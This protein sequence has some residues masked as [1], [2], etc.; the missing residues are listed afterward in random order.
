MEKVIQDV[1]L[2]EARQYMQQSNFGCWRTSGN[3]MK[4]ETAVDGENVE[5]W[6]FLGTTFSIAGLCVQKNNTMVMG[7]FPEFIDFWECMKTDY[8]QLFQDNVKGELRLF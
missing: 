2:E 6:I 4:E 8:S 5:T 3:Y 1:T 7:C